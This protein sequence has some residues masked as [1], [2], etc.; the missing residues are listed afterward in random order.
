MLKTALGKLTATSKTTEPR[1]EWSRGSLVSR[2]SLEAVRKR[3]FWKKAT[4]T[5]RLRLVEWYSSIT[6][7]NEKF[8]IGKI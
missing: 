3:K 7:L 6:S 1:R 5:S 4:D 2:K 8:K